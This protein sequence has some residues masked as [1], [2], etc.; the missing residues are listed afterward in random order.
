MVRPHH[1]AAG[2]GKMGSRPTTELIQLTNQPKPEAVDAYINNVHRKDFIGPA[3]Q[4]AG[5]LV[6]DFTIWQCVLEFLDT[7]IGN[8]GGNEVKPLQTHQPV[9]MHQSSVGDLGAA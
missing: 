8:L 9:Q 1:R 4:S 5:A 3:D 2:Q 7:R 6:D